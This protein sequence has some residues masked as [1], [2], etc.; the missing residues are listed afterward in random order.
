MTGLGLT[1]EDTLLGPEL[2]QQSPSVRSS[3]HQ[4]DSAPSVSKG[5]VGTYKVLHMQERIRIVDAYDVA[6]LSEELIVLGTSDTRSAKSEVER[7]IQELMIVGSE[8]EDDGQDPRR[9]NPYDPRIS[10][11]T[12]QVI[13]GLTSPDGIDIS[14]ANTDQ[15]TSHTLISNPQDPLRVSNDNKIDILGILHLHHQVS[16]DTA[17]GVREEEA[18]WTSPDCRVL[19]DGRPNRRSVDDCPRGDISILLG[20]M[21]GSTHW[22]EAP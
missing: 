15:D 3:L 1:I 6:E 9:I 4:P 11:Y 19:L 20:R 16:H 5:E 21:G 10:M 8:I 18:V 17:V 22:E 12:T 14:L 13:R 2:G 7:I